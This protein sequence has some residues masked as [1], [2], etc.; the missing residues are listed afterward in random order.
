MESTKIT[1]SVG[2]ANPAAGNNISIV[3]PTGVCWTA[4]SFAFTLV[5]SATAGTRRVRVAV[6]DVNGVIVA[7][8]VCATTEAASGTVLYSFNPYWGGTDINQAA[9]VVGSFPLADTAIPPGWQICTIT[10]SLQAGDQFTAVGVCV[11]EQAIVP[12]FGQ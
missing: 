7:E 8:T 6:K 2:G 9:T 10:D 11:V 3:V 12:G 1:K 4:R 5:T